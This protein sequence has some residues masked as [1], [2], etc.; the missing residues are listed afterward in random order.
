MRIRVMNATIASWGKRLFAQG[1][2][3]EKQKKNQSVKKILFFA[4]RP[5][6]GICG[7]LYCLGR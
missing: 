7:P 1:G 3:E 4:R 5:H 2:N 6:G